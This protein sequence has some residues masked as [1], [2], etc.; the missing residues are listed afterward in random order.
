MIIKRHPAFKIAS[1]FSVTPLPRVVRIEVSSLCNLQCIVCPTGTK[2]VGK[3]GNMSRKVF[4]KIINEIKAYNGVDV[5]VLYHGGEPFLNKNIFEMIDT[6]KSMGI[7]FVKTVTNGTLLN[8]EMLVKIVDSGLDSI[9]FSIDGL[10]PEENDQ[11]RKGADY[12]Q[13]ASVIKKLLSI[14]KSKGV[15]TPIIRIGNMQIPTEE[16]IRSGKEISTP[17]YILNDFSEFKEEIIFENTYM[18]KWPGFDCSDQYVL[19]EHQSSQCSQP[20]NYCDSVIEL[21]TFRW[22]GDV[23]PCCYDITSEYVIGNI[24]K[25]PLCEIW[26]NE[27]YKEIRK[28]IHTRQY[29]PLCLNCIMIKPQL[30]VARKLGK[31]TVC[32]NSP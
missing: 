19:V 17:E 11:I 3:R 28:S 25:Q 6:V 4:Y 30:F 20:S 9:S 13:I 22:N 21:I 23:V 8:E 12:Y 7:P 5:V 2:Y 18:L 27:R 32:K 24:M 1:D 26:N 16:D 14:K 31:D 15:S 10:S 29:V